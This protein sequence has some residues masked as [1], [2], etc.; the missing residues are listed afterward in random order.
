[1]EQKYILEELEINDLPEENKQQ[2]N[3]RI[4]ESLIKRITVEVLERLSKEEN[5]QFDEV[6]KKRDAEEVN[7]FLRSKIENYDNIIEKVCEEL[8]Q[9]IKSVLEKV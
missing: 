1:M 5:I 2:L 8:K 9:E 3:N 4:T 6:V 7:S